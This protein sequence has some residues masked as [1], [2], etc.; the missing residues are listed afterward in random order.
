M[1][2]QNTTSIGFNYTLQTKKVQIPYMENYHQKALFILSPKDDYAPNID[3]NE[4]SKALT[5][6]IELKHHT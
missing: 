6:K 2:R 4:N 1:E 5:I 3:A